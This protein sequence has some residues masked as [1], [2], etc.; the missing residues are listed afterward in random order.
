MK[1]LFAFVSVLLVSTSAFSA[2]KYDCSPVDSTSGDSNVTL[3]IESQDEVFIDA[4]LAN[5]DVN[6]TPNQNYGYQS[7][8]YASPDDDSY[9]EVLVQSK[10][11]HGA[12]T[13]FIKLQWRGEGFSTSKFACTLSN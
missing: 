12:K 9:N 10:L 2:T 5:L 8:D 4:D 13:G 3:N 1:N 7:F 11:L 6:Y